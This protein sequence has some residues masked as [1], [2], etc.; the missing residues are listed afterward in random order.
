M[1][2][3]AQLRGQE[4][5]VPRWSTTVHSRIGAQDGP[6]A[7]TAIA[8]LTVGRDGHLYV[9]Q[10]QEALVRVFDARGRPVRTIGREGKGP[11]EFVLPSR[12]GW[13]GDTLWVADEVQGR[14]NLFTVDGTPVRSIQFAHTSALTG[15][16]T[17]IPGD[18]LADGS[19]LGL[20]R[21]P[22]RALAGPTPVAVPLVRFTGG[23]RP[24]NQ[25]ARVERH[26]EYAMLESAGGVTFV[27]QPFTDTPL[28]EVTP[29]GSHLVIVTRPAATSA[30]RA[31]FLVRKIHFSGRT[32]FSGRYP[33][34][35]RPLSPREVAEATGEQAEG[36]ANSRVPGPP[37]AAAR[38]ALQ[39]AFYRPRFRPPVTT[40]LSGGDGTTWLR[41][42]E[43]GG[44][45]LWWVL[46]PGG[47]YLA[48]VL[49]PAALEVRYADRTQIWGVERDELDVPRV[50]RL[51][52]SA[53]RG[54]GAAP[55]AVP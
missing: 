14:I 28:W 12:M 8:G 3:P 2:W 42:E 31:E 27:R 51:R 7:M 5:A 24:L 26:N 6:A 49:L 55:G 45:V 48:T 33:Y 54:R 53:S 39:S 17:V 23:G 35:P 18:V 4:S 25:L 46:D 1:A 47:S 43:T 30:A 13:R 52:V 22:L 10:P 38:A 32:V 29:D 9:S 36:L 11:G 20:W 16:K 21:A 41:R 37:E 34:V 50:V 40:L 15:G 19:V 44:Q